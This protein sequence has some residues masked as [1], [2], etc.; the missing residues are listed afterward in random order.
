MDVSTPL[1]LLLKEGT[2]YV[3]FVLSCFVISWQQRVIAKKDETILTVYDR[4]LDDAKTLGGAYNTA[5]NGFS[6]TMRDVSRQNE[7]ITASTATIAKGV[8]QLIYRR[9]V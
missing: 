6:E 9:E 8:D 7:Q 3:L 1:A 5:I 4:R 2:G